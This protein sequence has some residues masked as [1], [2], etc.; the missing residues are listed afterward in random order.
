MTHNTDQSEEF[1]ELRHFHCIVTGWMQR[2]DSKAMALFQ[3]FRHGVT[4][5]SGPLLNVLRN[6]STEEFREESLKDL[7]THIQQLV[8]MEWIRRQEEQYSDEEYED[9]D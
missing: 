2:T 7:E 6:M 4:T 9:H 3:F 5:L 8:K 1:A